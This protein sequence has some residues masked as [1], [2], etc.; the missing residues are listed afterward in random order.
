MD[1]ALYDE[2]RGFFAKRGEA[3]RRGDFLTSPE[4]GPLFGAVL[5][6]ALDTWWDELGAPD[7]FVLIEAGAGT[8]T[9]W[10]AVRAAAPRCAA[11]LRPVLVER[12]AR[13]RAEH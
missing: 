11:A 12:S 2:Q 5:A 13:L 1:L 4:V 3:G 6:R 10:R 9:L 8:G 7:P